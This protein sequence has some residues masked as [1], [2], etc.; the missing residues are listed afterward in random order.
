MG[1]YTLKYVVVDIFL[2]SYIAKDFKIVWIK[3]KLQ[4]ML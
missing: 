2:T 3:L 1:P 4:P